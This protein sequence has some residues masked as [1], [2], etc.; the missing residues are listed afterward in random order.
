M[1]SN[2]GTCLQTF[3]PLRSEPKSSAE[4][5]SSIIFGESYQV[6]EQTKDWLLI[7]NDFDSYRGWISANTFQE[8]V[9]FDKINDIALIEAF[10]NLQKIYIPCGGLFPSNNKLI[11][12][13]TNFQIKP[14]LKPNH[15]LPVHLQ[16]TN[17]AK[18]FLNTPYLWGGRTFMGIDCSGFVQVV[19]KALG[20][21]LPRD[22]S[23]QILTG[24]TIEFNQ[25][26]AADLVF[27]KKPEQNQV[28]HVGIMINE[29][30]V[31][32]ASATVKI[33]SI[34]SFG[35]ENNK[36][37]EYQLLVCKRLI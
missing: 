5:V 26:K 16:I 4:M 30:E 19:F 17:L 9:F 15:H 10:S 21:N 18:S 32:H 28:S 2:R 35:I 7:I 33:N 22:T 13:Q 31:I 27:F 23:Q 20:V 12:N 34:S 8:E 25:I 29:N 37:L 11:L 36:Q 1:I 14:N 6:L 3:I 24:E